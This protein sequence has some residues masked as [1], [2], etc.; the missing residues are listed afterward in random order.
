MAYENPPNP[1][2]YYIRSVAAPKNVI[3]VM[4]MNTERAVC[5]PK[6]PK[7]VLNQQWYIQRSGRGYKIKNVKHDVY[8]TPHST[9]PNYG[10]VIGTSRVHGPVDWTFVRTHDGFS[11]QYGEELKLI[12]LHYGLDVNGNSM[13]LWSLSPQDAA[14]RWKFEWISDDVG[15]E[16]AENV[17]DRIAT[18]CDQLQRKEI[19]IATKNAELAARDQLLARQEQELRNAL[20]NRYEVSPRAIRAQLATLRA[21]IEGLERLMTSLNTMGYEKTPEPGTY[22]IRSVAAP[23]NVIEVL[24]YNEERAVCSPKTENPTLN[25]QWYVQR[26][27]RGYKI[28]NVKHGVYLASYSIKPKNATPV[29]TSPTHGPVDWYLIK[30]QDGF[31]IQYGDDEKAIDLHRGSDQY[32]QPMHL[33]DVAPQHSEHR[34]KFERVGDDVGGEVAETIEDRITVLRNQL[35]GKD[36][37]IAA[38]NAEIMAKDRLL[39]RYKQE[40]QDALQSR[41]EVASKVVQTQVAELRVKIEQLEFL[42]KSYDDHSERSNNTS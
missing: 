11:I 28:K 24:D 34:W 10:T 18:L 33:W 27:G 7:P 5:S 17:E 32:G 30:T 25:Q 19:E 26:S 16:V 38:K 9:R 6:V 20:Q 1:G 3:E 2:T 41:R 14:K 42:V 23:K 37:E 13:H 15:G 31:A 39:V 35:Q 40:L 36:I 21:N 4:D 22:Y 29:G 8:L 12:D